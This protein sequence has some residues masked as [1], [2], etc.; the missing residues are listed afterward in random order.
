MGHSTLQEARKYAGSY[1]NA[2]STLSPRPEL[3]T[4]LAVTPHHLSSL[5]LGFAQR[6]SLLFSS[7][8][9]YMSDPMLPFN[10]KNRIHNSQPSKFH[11]QILNPETLHT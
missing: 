3:V 11:I 8:I 5:P 10:L 4:P 1:P 2:R 6:S 7:W 9:T